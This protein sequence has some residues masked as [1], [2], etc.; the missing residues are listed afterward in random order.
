MIYGTCETCKKKKFFV[1]K[2]KIEVPFEK[3]IATSKKQMC[4]KCIN[5]IKVALQKNG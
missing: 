5:I 3:Q 2:R 4:R 1:K